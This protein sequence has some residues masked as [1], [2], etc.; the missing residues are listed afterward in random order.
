MQGAENRHKKRAHTGPFYIFMQMLLN[1]TLSTVHARADCAV[2]DGLEAWCITFRNLDLVNQCSLVQL[3]S[4]FDIQ[5]RSHFQQLFLGYFFC[6]HYVIPPDL[7]S[8]HGN[9]VDDIG[10]STSIAQ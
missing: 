1:L 7:V 4:T 5:F 3:G 10:K 6:T 2:G 8:T 9:C